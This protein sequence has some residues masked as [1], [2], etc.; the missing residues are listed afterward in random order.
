MKILFYTFYRW[1]NRQD[2]TNSEFTSM[3]VLGLLLGFNMISI[4]EHSRVLLGASP[5]LFMPNI[6]YYLVL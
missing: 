1:F 2:G 6:I 5:R 4:Y 3:Y